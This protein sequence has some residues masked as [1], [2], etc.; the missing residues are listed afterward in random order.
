M[1]YYIVGLGNPEERYLHTRHNVGWMVVDYLAKALDFPPF[2]HS[3]KFNAWISTKEHVCLVKPTTYMNKSGEALEKIMKFYVKSGWRSPESLSN[4][5]VVHDDL[6]IELGKF[7][8]QFG[9]GPKIHNG[10]NSI[11]R[12]VASPEFQYVRVGVDNRQGDRSLPG[13]VYVL[14]RFSTDEQATFDATLPA[15][16]N[17]L[18]PKLALSR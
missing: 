4:L 8:L 1:F 12:A 15:I 7:K 11:R 6:D 17:A 9:T 10:V 3:K 13:H 2:E 14:G 16:T 5:Y 18:I